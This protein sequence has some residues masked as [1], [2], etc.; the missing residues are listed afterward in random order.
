ML[1]ADLDGDADLDIIYANYQG[2]FEPGTAQELAIYQNDGAGNFALVSS[3]AVSGYSGKLRQVAVGDVDGD[4]DLDI[5]APAGRDGGYAFFI[6]M[7]DMVFVDEY[8]ERM[9]QAQPN[10]GAT[11]LGDFDNDGD[12]DIFS[13]DGYTSNPAVHGHV[14][15]NDGMG[16]FEEVDG[17]IPGGFSGQDPDDVD[18]LDVNGDFVLDILLNAHAGDNS[19]WLGNGDGTFSDASGQFPGQPQDFHYNPGV[20]DVDG[21][22]DLDVW[23]D[24]QGPSV[25]GGGVPTEQLLI[26]DGSGTFTD[27]TAARVSGNPNSDDN[28]VVCVDIDGDG[29]MDAI[30]INVSGAQGVPGVERLLVNA[31]DGTFSYA[32]GAFST[33]GNSGGSLW[34]EMG[35]LDG[36]GRLDIAFGNGEPDRDNEVFFG[37]NALVV[38]TLAPAFRTIESGSFE[39][40]EAIVVR[41]AIFD[42][43]V[44]DAGPRLS[45]TVATL[46]GDG[47]EEETAVTF[48]GG[49]LFRAEFPAQAAG[50]YTV[51]IC[52]TDMAGNEGCESTQ[53]EVTAGGG[54]TGDP[55][56][57]DSGADSSGSG[58]DSDS[59]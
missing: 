26:N 16:N 48:M 42:S 6:N 14:Y 41:V 22:G 47:V 39:A 35:D 12:L 25:G 50:S 27:E 53:V 3:T 38:D 20:C 31:G 30:V 8:A 23:V 33:Q 18:L 44:T 43:S 4:G 55:T 59:N 10:V 58:S 29:D 40:T 2:F 56:D 54:E 15:L 21:D 45:S 17:A 51:E 5:F 9:P 57:T 49:D 52:A 34:A 46:S 7:G 19:L 32:A 37:T 1:L 36:D 11:R 28:G 13:A 24:N